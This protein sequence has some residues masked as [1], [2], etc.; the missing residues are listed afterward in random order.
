MAT[1]VR[2]SIS[3]PPKGWGQLAPGVTVDISRAAGVLRRQRF[4]RQVAPED[5]PREGGD[6]QNDLAVLED[7]RDAGG[8][9]H[10]HGNGPRPLGHRRRSPMPG[11]QPL[12]QRNSLGQDV[13]VA[14]GGFDRAV[15]MD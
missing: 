14:G 3:D 10:R 4:T 1:K 7:P 9:A 2:M 11:A 13:D 8:F 6:V 5:G 12:A 15:P